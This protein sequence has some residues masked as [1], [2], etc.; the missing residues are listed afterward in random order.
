MSLTLA[1]LEAFDIPGPRYTSYPTAPQWQ[2]GFPVTTYHQALQ[3]SALSHHSLSVYIHIPFCTKMCYYC[4]CN[5]IIRKQNESVG[6]T[7]IG[8]LLKEMALVRQQ[9]S[10]T[11]VV[12]QVHLGG[13]TPNYLSPDQ[14]TR[15]LMGIRHTFQIEAGSEIAV[16]VDPRTLTHEQ[17]RVMAQQGVTRLSM[18]IQDTNPDV[19][20]SI[21]RVQ[22]IEMV[23]QAVDWVRAHGL[24]LNFDL[25]YGLP[26]QTHDG[27]VTTIGHVIAASPDRIALYSYA[28]VPWLKSHQSLLKPHQLP[29]G[30]DKLNLFLTAR[31]ALIAGGY[32]G[33]GMDH[34]ARPNDPLAVAYQT[35]TLYRNFMGYTLKPADDALG[36]GVTAIGHVKGVYIQNTKDLAHYYHGLDTEQLPIDRGLAL[37]QDDRM[38][39]WVI[40][41]IMCQFKLDAAAFS[42]LFGCDV[43]ALEGV[44]AHLQACESKGLINKSQS[45]F[46]VTELGKLFVRIV[47]MGFDAYLAQ[48]GGFSRTI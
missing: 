21:N 27:I 4:G 28:H 34:F 7:Y 17:V 10:A 36:F 16:E 13:G 18:G 23:R 26:K 25:I 12:K 35:G 37:S 41:S 24:S 3:Q 43:M 30:R 11:Q 40:Q 45:G 33:V 39:Q 19:Q 38:R 15:L 22:P 46:E 29:M 5:V 14:L 48:S 31:D 20:A 6:D 2:N 42:Q 47:A 32:Q 1:Q 44:P 9:L 8:Y